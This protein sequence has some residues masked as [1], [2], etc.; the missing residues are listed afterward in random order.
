MRRYYWKSNSK[1]K[2]PYRDERE[3]TSGGPVTKHI[4]AAGEIAERPRRVYRKL[5]PATEKQLQLIDSLLTQL[6]DTPAGREAEWDWVKKHLKLGDK[7]NR[8]DVELVVSFLRGRIS[9]HNDLQFAIACAH[10]TYI[11]NPAEFKEW[12]EKERQE[13]R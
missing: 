4:A 13:G 11:I 12:R 2:K 7:L 1:K 8:G 10:D 6:C 5:A 3:H 9:E